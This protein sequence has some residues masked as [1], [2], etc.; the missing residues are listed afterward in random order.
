MRT[1]WPAVLATRAF[2]CAL[3]FAT[4]GVATTAG[5]GSK[6][7]TLYPAGDT[8]DDGHGLLAQ[9]STKF[10]TDEE[11]DSLLGDAN[12]P[13]RRATTTNPYGGSTYGGSAYGGTSYGSYV[14]PAWPITAPNRSPKYSQLQTLS[15]AIEGTIALRAPSKIPCG[16]TTASAATT[17]AT[18]AALVFI[19][20]VQ[21]G[22]ALLNEGRP[23]SVGGTLVKRG[24]ALTPTIQI[25][26]PLPAA[27]AI[28]GDAKPSALHIAGKAFDLQAG[29]RVALQLA[30]G[31]TRV[32]IH[33]GASAWI[34]AMDTPYYAITDDRGRFRIDEL[35]AGT[36]EVTVWQPPTAK[37]SANNTITYGEPSITKRTIKVE[38]RR[39]SR[40]DVR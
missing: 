7:A 27:L 11:S 2:A 36:Y 26:T 30:A 24:C 16:T 15:G 22:R 8:R 28:H 20:K 19:E 34:V 21:V 3:A 9:A 10:M 1:W 4:A 25:V 39:S 13:R 35:A 12:N 38:N 6:Q 17:T 33:G 37:A 23:T 32:D 40:L 18:A 29:G 14:V 31:T 5:C